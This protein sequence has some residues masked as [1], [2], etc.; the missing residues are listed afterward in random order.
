M[1]AVNELISHAVLQVRSTNISSLFSTL[2]SAFTWGE[3]TM[4]LMKEA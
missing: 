2:K 3:A 1:M 4:A